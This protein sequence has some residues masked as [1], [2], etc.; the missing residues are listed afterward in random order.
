MIRGKMKEESFTNGS[1]TYFIKISNAEYVESCYCD[2]NRPFVGE[3]H[4]GACW[5]GVGSTGGYNNGMSDP[6]ENH[7]NNHFTISFC[8]EDLD[9]DSTDCKCQKRIPKPPYPPT[10]PTGEVEENC[11]QSFKEPMN[12]MYLGPYDTPCYLEGA[13]RDEDYDNI[14]EWFPEDACWE[15][16]YKAFEERLDSV[17][18]PGFQP[19]YPY[20]ERPPLNCCKFAVVSKRGF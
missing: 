1:T 11:W 16:A 20:E 17:G 18:E 7:L 5:G 12:D 10:N 15:R 4:S 19:S 9:E 8:N 2:N 13:V 14:S 3:F 6:G